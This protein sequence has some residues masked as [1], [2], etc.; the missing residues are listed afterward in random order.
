M[1]NDINWFGEKHVFVDAP[2]AIDGALASGS[3]KEMIVVMPSAY[4]VYMGSMYSN[5]VTTGN[6]EAFLTHDL[7]SYVDSHYRTIPNV[8][9]R[10]SIGTMVIY[11][12]P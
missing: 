10:R 1:D 11:L 2:K 12:G 8:P 4:T 3:A 9:L 7:V 6:W 5:S